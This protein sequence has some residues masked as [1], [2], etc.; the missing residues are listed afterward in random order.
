MV[1]TLVN[2]AFAQA[3][4]RVSFE[5]SRPKAEMP[6]LIASTANVENIATPTISKSTTATASA[7]DLARITPVGGDVYAAAGAAPTAVA[8]NLLVIAG[9]SLVISVAA[10]DKIAVIDR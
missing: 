4:Y 3:D 10:G 9:T 8:G 6:A 1:A 5:N 7:N 2:V